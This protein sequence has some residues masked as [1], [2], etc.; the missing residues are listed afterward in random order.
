MER[1][2]LHKRPTATWREFEKSFGYDDS[3][4][5]YDLPDGSKVKIRGRIDRIDDSGQ[6]TITVID[7]KTG[8]S[9]RYWKKSGEP[10]FKGGRQLQP[11]IYSAVVE[12]SLEVS[13]DQFEYR[14]PTEKG[15][16]DI[17]PYRMSDLAGAKQVIAGLLEHV[18]TGAFLPTTDSGDCRFCDYKS[19]CRVRDGRFG[20]TSP[21][22][23]WAKE[24][25]ANHPAFDSMRRRRGDN[26]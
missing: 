12:S 8:K 25:Q 6:G 5:W 9:N 20:A 13:V 17:V 18:S 7:Y 3:P 24:N 19:I 2:L 21:L 14:F 22:A 26:E 16:N 1:E 15:Q 10:A 23:D 11:A 4:S